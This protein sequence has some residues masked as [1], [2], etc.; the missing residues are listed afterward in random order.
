MVTTTILIYLVNIYRKNYILSIVQAKN[1][2]DLAEGKLPSHCLTHIQDN[3]QPKPWLKVIWSLMQY[4][5]DLA[6]T[7]FIK[8]PSTLALFFVWGPN[9]FANIDFQAT[10]TSSLKV[11]IEHLGIGTYCVLPFPVLYQV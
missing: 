7:E 11:T 6:C 2:T 1:K 9:Q 3:K 4:L 5:K 8:E 10:P